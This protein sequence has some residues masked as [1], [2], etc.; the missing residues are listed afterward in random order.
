MSARVTTLAVTAAFL[1]V[2]LAAG[3]PS[4]D[5]GP[6]ATPIGSDPLRWSL[7]ARTERVNV[8]TTG[9]QANGMTFRGPMSASG[10]FVAF[11]STAT[12]LVPEDHNGVED[13]FVRDRELNDTIRVSIATTGEEA[14]GPSYLP[15]LSGDGRLVAFRS[16]ATN[17]DPAGSQEVEGFFVHDLITGFTERIALGP[18][19][20]NPSRPRSGSRREVCDRWCV[21]A[22]SGDGSAFV[23]TSRGSRL[24]AGDRNGAR[25]VFVRAQGRTTRVTVGPM[26]E[27]DGPSEGS[28][29][30][31]DGRF[32]AFRSFASNLVR[33][34]TNR[35]PD[36]FV[37]DRVRGV[38]KRVNVSTAGE[39][40][41]RETFRPMLSAD[42][43][44]VGFRSVATNL[45]PGDSNRAL[46]VFVHD[47]ATGKTKRISIA[48]DRTQ[49]NA[50]G[51][52]ALVRH[53]LFMSRPFLSRHGRFAAFTSRAPNLVR[54]DTNGHG[55]VFV[56][57][58]ETRE[59]VRVS[60]SDRGGEAM[61]DSR[62]TGIS[63]DGRVV[64]FMSA[65]SNLVVRDTNGR[66]DYFV[67]VATPAP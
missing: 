36:L 56:H 21:N 37:R 7:G 27:A 14:N 61:S 29:I 25:D 45:V 20:E 33:R 12:N 8:S 58:L 38:T 5:R 49:A 67:R 24:V 44:F 23:F 53:T 6:S 18:T 48:T 26:G 15:L 10:R 66:R 1:P 55:D 52:S 16:V 43:R 19:G 60:V 4:A 51:M 39:E 65:A 57:D 31:A 63:A 32:V 34:D 30:S 11:S 50:R 9:E 17:L 54:R 42:G 62:V 64:G 46:D 35:V 28:S 41:N 59:T 22:V 13:V 47:R 40:A 2:L 3:Q